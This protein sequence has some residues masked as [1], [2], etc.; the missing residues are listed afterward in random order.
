MIKNIKKHPVITIFIIFF[1]L[2]LLEHQFLWLFH[3]DYG[4]A[5]L[6]YLP[7]FTGH[8]G[9]NT[10]LGDILS[11]LGF[12][13]QTW[14]GRVLY[15]FIEIILLRLS[16]SCFRLVQSLI[17]TGIF[18]LI[19]KITIR[20]IHK[21]SWPL[22]LG[23]CFCYG[24]FE[25]M[26][27]RGGIFWP[28]ASVLYLFPLL[29]FLF[30]VYLYQSKMTN[31]WL[32]IACFILIFLASFSQEQIATLCV[33]YTILMLLF[34]LWQTKKINLNNIIMFVGSSLGFMLLALCP[35]SRNRLGTDAA[36]ASLS[37][38][39]KIKANLPNI[40]INVF[41]QYTKIFTIIFFLVIIYFIYQNLHNKEL[42]KYYILNYLSLIS[43]SLILLGTALRDEGYFCYI[44]YFQDNNLWYILIMILILFQLALC[45]LS[46]ITYFYQEKE[47]KYCYLIMGAIGTQ[48]VMLIAPYYPLRSTIMFDIIYFLF[49]TYTLGKIYINNKELFKYIL[50]V[51]GII[52]IF[53]FYNITYGYYTN[54][55]VQR[56]DDTILRDTSSKIKLGEDIKSV[57]LSKLTSN[58]YGIEEPY[59][60]G[61]DYIL[62]YMKHYYDLP[63]SLIIIYDN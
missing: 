51:L 59:A 42:K 53:N 16:L 32:K 52:S 23:S 2:V 6:S 22:A 20:S 37:L 34:E 48:V 60:E 63:D 21:E 11:F 24:I 18:Y 19:Y 50:I 47:Y 57:K 28:T 40:L 3:D 14:G 54:Y 58:L 38:L 26:T 36:F 61:Y 35:G 30:Y 25:I 62:N 17:I 44:Y 9:M 1:F 13:Y 7:G 27:I 12:H 56:S 49:V 31:N 10:S 4:Y 55:E 29:P 15:F 5:S 45:L 43:T 33:A 39:G 46:I 8:M 41:G